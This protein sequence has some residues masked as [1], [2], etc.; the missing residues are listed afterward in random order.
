MH[1]Y[2]WPKINKNRQLL[3]PINFNFHFAIVKKK[4]NHRNNLQDE[5]RF[6][7]VFIAAK[8]HSFLLRFF[9]SPFV[10]ENLRS[11]Y[12]RVFHFSLKSDTKVRVFLT[13]HNKLFNLIAKFIEIILS[14]IFVF[15]WSETIIINVCG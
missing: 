14:L 13:T 1:I 2:Q 11:F 3:N 15:I 9:Y 8:L 10:K 5:F 7:E 4:R 12:M 6:E